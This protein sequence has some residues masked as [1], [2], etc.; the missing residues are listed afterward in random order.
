MKTV[1][2]IRAETM[3]RSHAFADVIALRDKLADARN[4]L[5][6]VKAD[7]AAR[8]RQPTETRD[9]IRD[10]V[11]DLESNL[12]KAEAWCREINPDQLLKHDSKLVAA[13]EATRAL[14]EAEEA[15]HEIALAEGRKTAAVAGQAR[16]EA[17]KRQQTEAIE[18]Q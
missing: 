7:L 5:A 12:N 8:P 6:A 1:N 3:E 11:A 14:R 18:Y 9:R 16:L 15:A 13:E 2:Q 10:H 4:R 17:R